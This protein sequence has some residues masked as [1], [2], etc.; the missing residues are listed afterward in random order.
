MKRLLELATAQTE[1]SGKTT[2]E[3]LFMLG[4]T[5]RV[6][7]QLKNIYEKQLKAAKGSDAK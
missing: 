6:V 4:D 1:D 7:S 3:K 2:K 5:V